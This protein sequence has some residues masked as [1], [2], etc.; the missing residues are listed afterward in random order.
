[1]SKVY[2]RNNTDT[3]CIRISGSPTT[4]VGIFRFQILIKLSSMST[5]F[6]QVID[7]IP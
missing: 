7:I 6:I 1:M 5:M 4:L 2:G 3:N